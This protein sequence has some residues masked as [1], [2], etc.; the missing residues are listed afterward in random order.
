MFRIAEG[1]ARV[2]NGAQPRKEGQKRKGRAH[3]WQNQQE[4]NNIKIN[5]M[6][7]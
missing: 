3:I 5:K 4:S 7:K 1:T 2:E 6:K